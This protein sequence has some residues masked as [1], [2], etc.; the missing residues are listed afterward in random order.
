MAVFTPNLY[1]MM[2]IIGLT[3]WVGYA[4]F[5]RAE[6]LSLC[7]DRDFVLAARAAGLLRAQWIL[8][9]HMLPNGLTPLIISASF[10]V[11]KR[12]TCRKHA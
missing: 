10:G 2:A 7:G 6:F 1:I 3:G 9:R 8:F 12:D 4:Y 11:A 5:I